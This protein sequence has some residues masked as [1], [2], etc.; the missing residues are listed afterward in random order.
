MVCIFQ[1]ISQHNTNAENQTYNYTQQNTQVES[2][3]KTHSKNQQDKVMF[4]YQNTRG[5]NL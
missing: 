1:D 5:C 4:A 2:E 3:M